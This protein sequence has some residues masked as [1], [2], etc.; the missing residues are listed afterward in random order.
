M[1]SM[2]KFGPLFLVAS[3]LMSS[4]ACGTGGLLSKP[5]PSSTPVPTS[6]FTPKP[7]LTPTITP[8]VAV[9]QQYEDFFSLV[10]GF[11]NA[12]YLTTTD[13]EYH[14]LGSYSNS[15]NSSG[16][17]A[18]IDSGYNSNNFILR[19]DMQLE[20][21]KETE[22][23]A[24][25]GISFRD[26]GIAHDMLSVG[27]DGNIYISSYMEGLQEVK[28]GGIIQTQQDDISFYKIGHAENVF[29]IQESFTFTLILFEDWVR[30][31]INEEPVAEVPVAYIGNVPQDWKISYT[32]ISGTDEGFGTRCT[33]DNIELWTIPE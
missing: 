26:Q 9:T 30:I 19:T 18:Q 3:L 24:G 7:T 28:P 5:T 14:F 13:G 10:Q 22:L 1:F 6:T 32:I 16:K 29:P 31:L 12:G 17:Y 2:K 20:T 15:L 23:L 21:S 4:L 33:F 8:N 27:S 25:C 11:V